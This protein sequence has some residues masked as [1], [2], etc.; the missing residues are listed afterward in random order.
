MPLSKLEILQMHN[1]TVDIYN[2]QLERNFPVQIIKITSN[3]RQLAVS[4]ELSN[5][6][7]LTI[8]YF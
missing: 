8:H 4:I 6:K 1:W 5:N 2:P 7:Q 3:I